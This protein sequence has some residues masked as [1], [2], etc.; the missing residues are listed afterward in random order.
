[1]PETNINERLDE[2]V[3][4][5]ADVEC[6]EWARD[7]LL[8]QMFGFGYEKKQDVQ[9]ILRSFDTDLLKNLGLIV[10]KNFLLYRDQE[11]E[12]FSNYFPEGALKVWQAG[13]AAY[14]HGNHQDA[15]NLFR[16]AEEGY[17]RREDNIN[18]SSVNSWYKS[19]TR[20]LEAKQQPVVNS[21]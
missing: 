15:L 7:H 11:G 10:N 4:A 2:I 5:L 8:N 16:L 20:K 12:R 13:I 17:K 18:A 21:Q 1:M 3:R 6:R 9:E 19:A 14:N